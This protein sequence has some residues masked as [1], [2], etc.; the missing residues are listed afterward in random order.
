MSWRPVK[1]FIIQSWRHD[2]MF[3]KFFAE[4]VHLKDQATSEVNYMPINWHQVMDWHVNLFSI[5]LCI[6]LCTAWLLSYR[7]K[8]KKQCE[9]GTWFFQR[10]PFHPQR[11]TNKQSMRFYSKPWILFTKWMCHK[12]SHKDQKAERVIAPTSFTSLKLISKTA[13][14]IFKWFL[15]TFPSIKP[16]NSLQLT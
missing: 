12:T 7:L 9:W 15:T 4:T 6:G 16:C 2:D 3:G 10:W 11:D 1:H 13:L 14:N 5:A 8:K